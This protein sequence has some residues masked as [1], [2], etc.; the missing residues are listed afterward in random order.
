MKN[1][2]QSKNQVDGKKVFIKYDS[3][4][5]CPICKASIAPV[6]I[7]SSLNTDTTA[8]VF[9]F[10]PACRET[11]VTQY[12]G[13]YS[14]KANTAQGEFTAHQVLYSEPNRYTKKCF[15]PAIEKLSP[16]F[17]EIYNQALCAETLQLDRISGISYRKAVEFLIKDYVIMIAEDEK[18][19][20]EIKE[21]LLSAC[22][23]RYI[24]DKRILTLAERL[25]WLGND[26]AH[27]I[28]KHEDRD[29]TDIKAFI[30][31]LVSSIHVDLI[32]RD[33]ESILPVK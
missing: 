18:T 11:F 1:R 32:T 19:I 12:T 30:D 20:T 21:M 6:Y 33:A 10:C 24:E 27:Y 14:S 26:E 5:V 8:S 7:E 3:V 16:D 23:K 22:I 4:N 9:N 13:T 28:R 15:D 17:V 2:T 25:A 29:I 31:A